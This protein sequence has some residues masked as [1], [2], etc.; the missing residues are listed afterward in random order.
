MKMPAN[1]GFSFLKF[2]IISL[3]VH[4]CLAVTMLDTPGFLLGLSIPKGIMLT[5]LSPA[6]T[7]NHAQTVVRTDG[8]RR[9]TK[10]SFS[11]EEAVKAD[12][13]I[14][15]VNDVPFETGQKTD[16]EAGPGDDIDGPGH[17][18]TTSPSEGDPVIAGNEGAKSE[19][20]EQTVNKTPRQEDAKAVKAVRERLHFDVFWLNFHVGKAVIETLKDRN[21]VKITSQ[22]HSNSFISNFFRVED[23][24]ESMIIDGMP[25]HFRIKQREG[26]YSSD[27][28]TVFDDLTEKI[29]YHN[30][31]KGTSSE[32]SLTGQT[33]W[34]VMSGFHHLRSLA[35][36]TGKTVF[37]DIFDS[38]KFYKAEVD[39]LGKER[40]EL[41]GRGEI[42]T[43]KIKPQL[44]SEGLF[45][46]KG[47]V[48]IWLSDDESRMPVMVETKVPIGRVIARLNSSEVVE[49]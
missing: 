28:E 48:L 25:S 2:I 13:G 45:Q 49:Q 12:E 5:Y 39:V 33:Y 18:E 7:E 31:L 4:F 37:I 10:K 42:E 46:S 44:K 16:G 24:A 35:L 36:E 38:D 17:K 11:T 23:Y 19:T 47:D 8:R 41:P 3:T 20:E 9:P 43:V 26:K 30:H 22:V 6:D 32:H 29:I 40:L 21:I 27:R 34:D 1:A 15:S 14:A